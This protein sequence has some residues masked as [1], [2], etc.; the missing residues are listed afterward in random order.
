M[1]RGDEKSPPDFCFPARPEFLSP[2]AV[3]RAKDW[4][5]LSDFDLLV[6]AEEQSGRVIDLKK[7]RMGS[8]LW[9][10]TYHQPDGPHSRIFINL[11]LP[12][13]WQRFALYHELHH[14]LYDSLKGVGIYEHTAENTR[15][16]EVSADDFAWAVLD[17]EQDDADDGFED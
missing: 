8:R 2:T 5:F 3:N 15:R 14:L 6:K 11:D 13:R 9:G 17:L 7:A 1:C 4:A 16:F 10:F 12:H